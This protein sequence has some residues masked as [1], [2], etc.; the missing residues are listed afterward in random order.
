MRGT[1]GKGAD[2]IL[3]LVPVLGKNPDVVAPSRFRDI[4]QNI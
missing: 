4:K 1:R 2:N 3:N